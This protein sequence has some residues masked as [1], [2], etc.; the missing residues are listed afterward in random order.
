MV[1]RCVQCDQPESKCQCERYCTLCQ[2][3]YNVRLVA[4]GLYYCVDCREACDYRT[5]EGSIS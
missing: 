3:Q 2:S 5:E 4:D 1:F